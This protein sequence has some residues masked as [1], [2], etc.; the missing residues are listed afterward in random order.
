[1]QRSCV[2]LCRESAGYSLDQLHGIAENTLKDQL[3]Q[4]GFDVSGDVSVHMRGYSCIS[5]VVADNVFL[6]H[7]YPIPASFRSPCRPGRS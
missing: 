3:Q 6:G 5:N 2:S 7:G 1:M 4:L